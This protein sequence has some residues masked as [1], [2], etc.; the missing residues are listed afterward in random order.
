MTS[1]K[2]TPVWMF[3]F[4]LAILIIPVLIGKGYGYGEGFTN[5]AEYVEI[6]ANGYANTVW[7]IVKSSMHFDKANG[8]IVLQTGD[9]VDKIISRKGDETGSSGSVIK[10]DAPLTTT[11]ESAWTSWS[12][13][14][15]TNQLFYMPWD[16]TT[17]VHL[18]TGGVHTS[19]FCFNGSDKFV[20]EYDE[21]SPGITQTHGYTSLPATNDDRIETHSMFKKKVFHLKNANLLYDISSGCIIVPKAADSVV[22]YDRAGDVVNYEGVKT[23][24]GT[25]S[26]SLK[27]VTAGTDE[28]KIDFS[29][30]DGGKYTLMSGKEFKPWIFNIA[31]GTGAEAAEN[32]VALA[33]KEVV[34][35]TDLKNKADAAVAAATTS[36]ATASTDLTSA[37]KVATDNLVT[38]TNDL[39]TAVAA[40]NNL[41]TKSVV[42]MPYGVKTLIATFVKQSDNVNLID[43]KRFDEKG[44]VSSSSTNAS[45]SASAGA[46]AGADGVPKPEEPPKPGDLP[47]ADSAISEY[48]KWYWYWNKTGKTMSDDYMLKTQVVPPVC[49]SC[50]VAS[51]PATSIVSQG[52]SGV[53]GTPITSAIQS[54]T[55][56][57]GDVIKSLGSGASNIGLGAVDLAKGTVGETADLAR[58]VVGGTTGLARDVVGGTVG[59]A[60]GAVGGTVGLARDTVG[61]TIGL[62]KDVVGGTVGL[63]KDVVGGTVDLAK[64]AFGSGSGSR[65]GS[66][67][68]RNYSYETGSKSGSSSNSGPGPSDPYTYNGALSLKPTSTFMPVTADFSAFSR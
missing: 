12:A 47:S 22:I 29:L 45:A 59:L 19:G 31:T 24:T 50:P 27:I 53:G 5:R 16:K 6:T 64:G 1:F 35:K 34:A 48:Y 21:K 32:A 58:D 11:V 49:P 66:G 36:T 10:L 54:V 67:S 39:N 68:S 56:T 14:R 52:T 13:K 43:V 51:C 55:G 46:G 42:I 9:V 28:G 26:G 15:E 2:L 4:L 62:A 20:G 41:V 44:L 38:V 30:G 60:A 40:L 23:A 61:G 18:A 25:T 17:F 33:K 57:T 65:S 7:P 37:A 63:A 8:N 3:I